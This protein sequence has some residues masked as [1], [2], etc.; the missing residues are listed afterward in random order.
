VTNHVP[1]TCI[2]LFERSKVAVGMDQRA[3][4]AVLAQTFADYDEVAIRVVARYD[5]KPMHDAAVVK[6]NI[7]NSRTIA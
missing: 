3:S 4:V 2:L 7:T 5:T 6:L 1:D